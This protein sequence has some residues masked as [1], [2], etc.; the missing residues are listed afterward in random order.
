MEEEKLS[1]YQR[2]KAKCLAQAKEYQQKNKEK[3]KLYWQEYYQINKERIS[4]QQRD[5]CA[6]NREKVNA[7]ALRRYHRVHAEAKK[8]FEERKAALKAVKE[9]VAEYNRQEKERQ[10]QEQIKTF[11]SSPPPE[12]EPEKPQYL[13]LRQVG[14]FVVGWD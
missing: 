5:Y 10:E 13:M 12:P 4:K 11:F 3:Y 2:N 6:K 1:Y 9:A 14:N 7:T 8:Q